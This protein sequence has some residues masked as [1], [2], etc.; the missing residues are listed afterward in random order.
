MCQEI[1]IASRSYL[2][3][4]NFERKLK[5]NVSL[6]TCVYMGAHAACVLC[7]HRGQRTALVLFPQVLPTCLETGSHWAGVHRI[8]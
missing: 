3:R 4:D 8:V 1:L 2:L 7:A 5:A 6:C